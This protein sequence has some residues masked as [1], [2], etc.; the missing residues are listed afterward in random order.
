MADLLKLKITNY[1]IQLFNSI[2]L[3][4]DLDQGLD[5]ELIKKVKKSNLDKSVHCNSPN[6]LGNR[7]TLEVALAHCFNLVG[8]CSNQTTNEK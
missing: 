4:A 7:G 1:K 6:R 5:G 8:F 2:P 3:M